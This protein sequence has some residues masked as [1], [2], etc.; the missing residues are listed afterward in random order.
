[1]EG[2]DKAQ[3]GSHLGAR[4]QNIAKAVGGLPPS[5][6]QA[7]RQGVEAGLGEI[8]VTTEYVVRVDEES[9]NKTTN[10]YTK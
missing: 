7:W 9:G 1:M 8:V 3:R 4:S 2:T 5:Q 6:N 10:K